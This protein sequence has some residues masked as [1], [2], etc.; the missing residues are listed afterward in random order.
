MNIIIC[1]TRLYYSYYFSKWEKDADLTTSL[2][3]VIDCNWQEF[4]RYERNCGT[5]NDVTL[6]WTDL[7]YT[8]K[9]LKILKREINSNNILYAVPCIPKDQIEDDLELEERQNYIGK[10]AEI[11]LHSYQDIPCET[12][13]IAHDLDIFEEESERIFEEEDL[14]AGTF[15]SKFIEN[16]SFDLNHI[17]GFQ[18]T[19]GNRNRNKM[20]ALLQELIDVNVD[21]DIVN[22]I[23]DVFKN[24]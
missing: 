10:I 11:V 5:K 7:N 23:L 1:S 6:Y 12:F 20:F 21:H 8:Y 4:F 3:G 9:D 14:V 2:S 16:Y 22:K 18:H 24:A 17:Y 15:L 13:I 19:M